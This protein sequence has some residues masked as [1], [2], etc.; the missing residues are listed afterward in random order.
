MLSP[1]F[2][3]FLDRLERERIAQRDLLRGCTPTEIQMLE[4]RYGV[5]L[6]DAYRTY[7]STM[8][9]DSG[10]LF[11]YDYFDATYADVWRMT[12]EERGYAAEDGQL[13]QLDASLGPRGLIVVGRLSGYYFFIS[14][15]GGEDAPVFGFQTSDYQ[16]RPRYDS[17]LSFLNAIADECAEAVR[18]G[19]FGP[20]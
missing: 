16:A 2:A 15:A 3:K 9:H 10:R 1:S 18:A 12:R 4:S 11:R 6:P 5:A 17:L 19:Y 13:E 7:L 8:G 20:G 14:C